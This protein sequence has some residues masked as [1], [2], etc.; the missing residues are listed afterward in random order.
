MIGLRVDAILLTPEIVV[1]E[2]ECDYSRVPD[3]G[4][5]CT[6]MTM[7]DQDPERILYVV[8]APLAETP[9]FCCSRDVRN[10]KSRV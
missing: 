7:A 3:S 5:C 1:S 10:Y 2:A 9:L 4:P 8:S 6:M